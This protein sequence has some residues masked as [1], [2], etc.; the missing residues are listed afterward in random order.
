MCE[1]PSPSTRTVTD[2]FRRVTGTII[3]GFL[4]GVLSADNGAVPLPEGQI[5]PD[6]GGNVA[7]RQ[8][9]RRSGRTPRYFAAT[10]DEST[11]VGY[12]TLKKCRSQNRNPKF[13]AE[14]QQKG[15]IWQETTGLTVPL[16]ET[17]I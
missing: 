2:R 17:V 14:I 7:K 16:Q 5:P 11:I 8:R 1:T 9:G 4:G 12:Y 13:T 6:S 15:A 10:L 3:K